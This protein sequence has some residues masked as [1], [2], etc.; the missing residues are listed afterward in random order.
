MLTS[1]DEKDQIE[2]LLEFFEKEKKGVQCDDI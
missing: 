2:T 1:N